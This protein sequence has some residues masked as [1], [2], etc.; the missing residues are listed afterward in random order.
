[1]GFPP[2]TPGG[3]VL[4][5]AARS[6]CLLPPSRA[7]RAVLTLVAS[8]RLL[9]SPS[10]RKHPLFSSS[11]CR[12]RTSMTPPPAAIAAA[13]SGRRCLQRPALPPAVGAASSGR[14]RLLRPS[15]PPA[16]VVVAFPGRCHLLRQ[17]LLLPPAVAT[18]SSRSRPL[19]LPPAGTA[20]P[21]GHHRCLTPPPAATDAI[22]DAPS[23]H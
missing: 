11:W 16:V 10:G 21:D 9:S 7:S 14:R 1:M 2:P 5:G 12:H 23:G 20:A 8:L 17:S 4:L 18:A 3:F 19:S 13:S 22:A 6:R 15:P